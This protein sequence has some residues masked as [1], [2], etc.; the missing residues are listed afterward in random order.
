[1]LR[2]VLGMIIGAAAGSGLTYYFVGGARPAPASGFAAAMNPA[3]MNSAATNPAART[4]ATLPRAAPRAETSPRAPTGAPATPASSFDPSA[5]PIELDPDAGTN[6]ATRARL[7]DVLAITNPNARRRELRNLAAALA[8]ENPAAALSVARG[9]DRLDDRR[10][11]QYGLVNELARIDPALLLESADLLDDSDVRAMVVQTLASQVT[12]AIPPERLV[13]LA[14]GLGGQRSMFA[15]QTAVERWAE[16]DP[17]AA[18]AYAEGLP[19]GQQRE[20]VLSGVVRSYAS[21]DPEAA[22]AWLA[23]QRDL[24]EEIEGALYSGIAQADPDRALDLF[25][26]GD[27]LDGQSLMGGQRGMPLLMSLATSGS[28]DRERIADRLLD[29]RD[30]LGPSYMQ[31]FLSS[32]SQTAPEDTMSWLA[33]NAAAIDAGLLEQVASNLARQDPGLVSDLTSQ[34]PGTVRDRWIVGVAQGYAQQDANAALAWL[35]Q[36]AGQ[37]VYGEAALVVAQHMAQY[38]APRAA[39]LLASAD[40]SD[41]RAAAAAASLAF[42]WARTNPSAAQAWVRGLP[43]GQARDGGLSALI[44]VNGTALPDPATLSLFSDDRSREQAV[45]NVIVRIA[46][47]DATRARQLLDERITDTAIRERVERVIDAGGPRSR[48]SGAT[49]ITNRGEVIVQQ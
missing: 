49:I 30:G 10:T 28:I 3:A 48:F 11:F 9:L 1:M 43:P 37:P 41:A 22:L 17:L 26:G 47:D 15:L 23:A 24:S 35:D 8:R 27:L 7:D 13:A 18:L 42:H 4:T 25:L 38:D 12:S 40:M 29:V 46:R 44:G 5:S 32:W 36:Y 34:V 6:E 2:I 33:R 20:R 14:E 45:A 21:A 16:T 39:A 19:A 31:M